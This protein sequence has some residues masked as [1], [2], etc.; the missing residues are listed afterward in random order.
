MF[1]ALAVVSAILLV[2]LGALIRA[3]ISADKQQEEPV[4]AG[5]RGGTDAA[6]GLPNAPAVPMV[7]PEP[8]ATITSARVEPP[9]DQPQPEPESE[10]P[11][12]SSTV[13]W[14]AR[15]RWTV[16]AATGIPALFYLAFVFH[17]AVNVPYLDDW[18]LLQVVPPALHGHLTLSSLW[19][20]YVE[21]RPVTLRLFLVAFGALDHLN[22]RSLLMFSAIT[23]IGSFILL[24][25]LFRAYLGKRLTFF[26]VLSVGVLWFS[27]ADVQDTLWAGQLSTFLGLFFIV[28]TAYLLLV[29]RRHRKL[30]FGLGIAA[31]VAAS[32]SVL[33]GFT[34]WPVGLVCLLWVGPYARRSYKE[35][36]VW[37][38]AF[39]VTS[40]V[41]LHGYA[42][43][44]GA[45]VVE[46]GHEESCGIK[47]GLQHPDRMARL[48]V[49]VIG[50]IIPANVWQIL[51]RYQRAQEVLGVVIFLAAVFVIV[52]SIRERHLHPNP[53]PFVLIVLGLLC[54]AMVATSH[55][56]Q[57]L[58]V[59]AGANRFTLEN[60]ILVTGIVVYA[61]GRVLG[62]PE[63]GELPEPDEP[64]PVTARQSIGWQRWLERAGFATLIAFLVVLC[65]LTT[66]FGIDTARVTRARERTRCPHRREPRQ[67]STSGK[68]VLRAPRIRVPAAIPRRGDVRSISRKD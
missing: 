26:P 52:Q 25:L 47:Y 44:T 21:L 32:L 42:Y 53:L 63:P 48:F 41:Y 38:L 56:G 36:A 30:F 11:T 8:E 35:V 14:T 34:V 24:L 40:A 3:A 58:L 12:P 6:D 55:L 37:S 59:G 62:P 28:A 4:L 60:L 27:L 64:R 57:G 9:V 43:G 68:D 49:L 39:V 50:N 31:A 67:G 15:E 1:A 17:Y 2:T 23:R 54:D 22:L 10:R 33:Q 18:N 51:P 66:R 13:A 7:A 61:W 20:E 19:G 29:P 45:C 5:V 16:A 46:G 65:A